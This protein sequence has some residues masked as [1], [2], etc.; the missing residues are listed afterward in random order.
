[1]KLFKI[2]NTQTWEITKIQA[3]NNQGAIRI[4][5][6]KMNLKKFDNS[7]YS[8]VEPENKRKKYSNQSFHQFESKLFY[9][10]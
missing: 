9:Q 5:K 2:I 3:E 1:M 8:V 7:L 10:R 6:Q 4:F